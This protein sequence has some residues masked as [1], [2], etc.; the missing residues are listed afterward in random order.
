MERR[1]KQQAPCQGAA[2]QRCAEMSKHEMQRAKRRSRAG[3]LPRE[4]CR[5]TDRGPNVDW[6]QGQGQQC[7]VHGRTRINPDA[8]AK[9]EPQS[10]AARGGFKRKL[11]AML[12]GPIMSDRCWRIC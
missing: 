2:R 7:N 3:E 1:L 10:S 5:R 12:A 6:V 4:E 8:N 11:R 9:C